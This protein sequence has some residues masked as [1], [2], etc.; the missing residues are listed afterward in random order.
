MHFV[1]SSHKQHCVIL[2]NYV[3]LAICLFI[4][5]KPHGSYRINKENIKDVLINVQ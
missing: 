2:S 1:V 4:N 3:A 5:T